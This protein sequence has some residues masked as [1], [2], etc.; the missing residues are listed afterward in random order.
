MDVLFSATQFPFKKLSRTRRLQA[1][2]RIRPPG[3]GR[4]R[5]P[6]RPAHVA[7]RTKDCQF[8]SHFR[9]LRAGKSCK[10]A[11]FA[12]ACKLVR[13]IHAV[14]KNRKPARISEPT[15]GRPWRAGMPRAGSA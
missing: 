6:N 7:S 13:V 12:A 1:P 3:P 4:G 11:V 14:L 15:A 8:Y 9:A 10:Q 5:M 2:D